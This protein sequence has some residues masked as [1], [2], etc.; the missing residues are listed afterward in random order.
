MT[1]NEIGSIVADTAMLRLTGTKLGFLLNF[2]AALM[3][4]GI[5]RAV[6]NLRDVLIDTLRALRLERR[7]RET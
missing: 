4:N 6:N 5:P 3:K 2:G 7:G 1:E